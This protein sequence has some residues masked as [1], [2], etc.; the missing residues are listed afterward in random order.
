MVEEVLGAQG[1]HRAG[2]G[3]S[4]FAMEV[5]RVGG[6]TQGH[7]RDLP[8][9][10][11]GVLECIWGSEKSAFAHLYLRQGRRGFGTVR[12]ANAVA[13]PHISST[14]K[15]SDQP[16]PSSCD[17]NPALFQLILPVRRSK[18]VPISSSGMC[19]PGAPRGGSRLLAHAETPRRHPP[20]PGQSG[21]SSS[22][23]KG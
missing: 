7:Q 5:M 14:I 19:Q 16:H 8:D 13:Q 11:E 6:S 3:S 20:V 22:Y 4:N 18:V 23:K 15:S 12:E 1:G 17:Q 2:L 10:P 21:G 9:F